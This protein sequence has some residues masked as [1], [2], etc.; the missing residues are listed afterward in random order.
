M[1][2]AKA[3]MGVLLNTRRRNVF[4]IVSSRNAAE[5]GDILNLKLI[6]ILQGSFCPKFQQFSPR[7]NTYMRRGA[8]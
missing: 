4:N 5:S 6:Q 2:P 7:L 3:F 8:C 1:Q